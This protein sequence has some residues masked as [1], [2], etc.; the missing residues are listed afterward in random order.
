M[1]IAL[2]SR[3]VGRRRRKKADLLTHRAKQNKLDVSP[4]VPGNR[5]QWGPKG[6]MIPSSLP[7]RPKCKGSWQRAAGTQCLVPQDLPGRTR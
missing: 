7:S 5:Y 6:P 1:L 2:E 3:E 4:T